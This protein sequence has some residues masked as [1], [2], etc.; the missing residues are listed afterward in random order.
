MFIFFHNNRGDDMITNYEIK[1]IN[2]EE[3]IV[4]YLDFSLEV[5]SFQTGEKKSLLSTVKSYLKQIKLNKHYQKILVMSSGVLIATILYMGNDLKVVPNTE[6]LAN[7]EIAI[8]EV[9]EAPSDHLDDENI[10]ISTL[11]DDENIQEKM[12]QEVIEE[13]METE[14][15][16]KNDIPA[17][18]VNNSSSL[19][20]SNF[21]RIQQPI[22]K[23]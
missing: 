13:E 15:S 5:G 23:K 22:T 1:K 11:S 17:N 21:N 9:V 19:S 7:S 3:V 18:E 10:S 4:L 20:D 2:K 8:S 6:S 14:T 12:G 16:I